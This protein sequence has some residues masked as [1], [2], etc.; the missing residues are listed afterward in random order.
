MEDGR[1][2]PTAA[3]VISQALNKG[4]ELALRTT[5]ITAV[6]ALTGAIMK[7]SMGIS[8]RV[9]FES[10]RDRCRRELDVAADDPDLPLVFGFLVSVGTGRNT[11]IDDFLAYAAKFV[12]SKKNVSCACNRLVN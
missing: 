6:A 7:E 3:T 12:D 9:A 8:Q 11:F 5:E 10:V 2:E 1:G 4:S